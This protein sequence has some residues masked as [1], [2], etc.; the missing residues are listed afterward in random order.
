MGRLYKNPGDYELLDELADEGIGDFEEYYPQ[1]AA[2]ELE[3]SDPFYG[4]NVIWDGISGRTLRVYADYARAIDGNIFDPDKLSAV[5]DGIIHAPNRTVLTAPYGTVSVVTPQ[6]IKESIEYA[7][8]YPD[9]VLTTGDSDLDDYLVDPD[10]FDEEEQAESEELLTEAVA[11]G[12][13]DLGKL[14]YTI[15]DGNHRAFGA[16][17]AGEPYIW[18][19]LEDN[20][21]Q[22]LDPSKYPDDQLIVDALD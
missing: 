11:N 9:Y 2:G 6:D 12:E 4:R 18:M 19:I 16:L 3:P 17:L 10:D 22:D 7:D 5:R 15:R 13:G 21:F 8:D 1:S 14:V 20:Q